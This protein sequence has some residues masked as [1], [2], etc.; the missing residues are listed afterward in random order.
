MSQQNIYDQDLFFDHFK[1]LRATQENFNELIEK[2]MLSSLLPNLKGKKIL[3]IGCGMGHHAK[4]YIEAGAS[5]VIGTDLS[6]KMLSFA[7]ENF[8]H[9][10]IT[11]LNLSAEDIGELKENFDLITSSLVFD[12]IEDLDKLF[13]DVYQLLSGGGEFVFSMSHPM[14]TAFTGK[15]P[16]WSKDED[17]RKLY[18]H[19]ENYHQE[20]IRKVTWVL[21]NHELYHRKVST[22]INTLIQAGFIIKACKEAEASVELIEKYPELLSGLYHRPDF[23][24]FKCKKAR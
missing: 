20:G 13:K 23:I 16:R 10:K 18:A 24:F 19:L 9:E 12:Y 21:E 5:Q 2:P 8:S 3:D 6:E 7:K 17:G 1:K 4:E 15:Y 11:Y 22:I 14:A